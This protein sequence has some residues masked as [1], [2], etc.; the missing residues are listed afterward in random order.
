MGDENSNS[1]EFIETTKD[2]G[3][4]LEKSVE[5]VFQSAGFETKRNVRLAKYEI[6][7][8]AEIGDR[9]IIIEC[10]NFQS[11]NLTIRN[12]IH[13]WNS[14]NKIIKANKIIIV[15]AGVKVKSSDKELASKFDIEIWNDS[16][17]TDFFN[18]TLKP[19]Q[20]REELLKKISFR[21][22]TISE[23]YRDEI[24]GIVITPHLTRY[25]ED[26][27]ETYRLFNHWLRSFIRTELQINGTSKEERMMHIELFEG[28]KEKRGFFNL[29][30]V[31]RKESK[32]WETVIKRL[33]KETILDKKYQD[34]YHGYMIDL[35]EEYNTQNAY[36]DEENNERKIKKLIVDRLYNSL[37]FDDGVC[38]FGFVSGNTVRV[39]AIDEGKFVISVENIND[40]QANLINWVLTSEYF[41]SQK[42]INETT[43]KNIYSWNCQSL[44][45]A[46]DKIYRVLDEFYSY[47][48]S[49][50]LRDFSL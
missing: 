50:E 17:L 15:I 29:F 14:K 7:V 26:E 31:K 43:F 25:I 10:K 44:D 41:F 11:S 19:T 45:E 47:T 49:D 1:E 2:K 27:E 9:N 24:A 8:L 40:K 38:D 20:L 30:K 33:Q 3:S 42:M 23:L 34:K 18:L 36:Y 39:E 6:D 48:S 32:Y 16:D 4:A 28:T 37:L 13:Q 22:I 12:I 46:S 21:P 35:I 5:F